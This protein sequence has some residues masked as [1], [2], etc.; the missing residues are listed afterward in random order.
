MPTDD[1][2]A[3]GG[4]ADH[5]P[6]DECGNT[7][8]APFLFLVYSIFEK[9]STVFSVDGCVPDIEGNLLHRD[10]AFAH[11]GRGEALV[12]GADAALMIRGLEGG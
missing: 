10:G 11:G 4:I 1:D 2:N 5:L 12:D 9:V 7:L 6:K 3:D 8:I